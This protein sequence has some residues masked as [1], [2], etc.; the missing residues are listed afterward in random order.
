MPSPYLCTTPTPCILRA[1]NNYYGYSKYVTVPL[2]YTPTLDY[3][4]SLT[5]SGCTTLSLPV[6]YF[7]VA[8]LEHWISLIQCT[9]LFVIRNT[10]IYVIA[11][12][13]GTPT[14]IG[15]DW[16]R[17]IPYSSLLDVNQSLKGAQTVLALY[18]ASQHSTLINLLVRYTPLTPFYMELKNKIE[19]AIGPIK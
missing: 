3:F 10:H 13:Q 4:Y 16:P 9:H 19:A 14:W 5:P 8:V 6:T 15:L 1:W 12:I 11:N 17:R 18:P 2:D 7:H